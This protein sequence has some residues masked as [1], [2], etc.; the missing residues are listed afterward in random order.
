MPL[1][2][3]AAVLTVAIGFAVVTAGRAHAQER[4]PVEILASLS[5]PVGL[6]A[7]PIEDLR[8]RF[9]IAPYRPS[10]PSSTLKSL[11]VA[12]ALTQALDVHSTLLAL[13]R[14]ANE[15]NP[16]LGGLAHR[17]AA[18]IALKAGATV[19]TIMA[20]RNLSRRN[21]VAAIAALVAINSAYAVVIDHNY[22]VAKRLR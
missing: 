2:F 10:R 13:G 22:R 21:R 4:K 12:T 3:A 5:A 8:E 6:A 19:S 11:Y 17:K 18:F 16:L 15:V 1:R 7:A 9:G 20:A 14:G